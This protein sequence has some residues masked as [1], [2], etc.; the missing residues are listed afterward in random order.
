MTKLAIAAAMIALG[1][2][3]AC[4]AAYA[5]SA[6]FIAAGDLEDGRIQVFAIEPNGQIISRWKTTT[7]PNAGWTAWS[8]FQ[9][10]PGGVTSI[11]VGYLSD[12]RPQLF[13]TE[14]GGGIVSCWK[15]TADPNA[16]W[17]PWT[18]F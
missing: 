4:P 15:T 13:A 2:S 1:A 3:L 7:D 6:R 17:T 10:P 8:T 14:T 18:A 12:K 9:T 5:Q 11:S 16:G